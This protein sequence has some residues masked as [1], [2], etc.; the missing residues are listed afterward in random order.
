MSTKVYARRMNSVT[1]M[2][3]PVQVPHEEVL[4]PMNMIPPKRFDIFHPD[5]EMLRR[6]RCVQIFHIV[7]STDVCILSTTRYR[8]EDLK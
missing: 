4:Q 5:W 7:I 3:E 1:T 8:Q 6:S 2:G